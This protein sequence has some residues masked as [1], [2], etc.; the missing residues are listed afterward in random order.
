MLE[1]Q[2]I[3][4]AHADEYRQ[5]HKLPIVHHKALNAI[6]NCRTAK[7]GGHVDT[8][9]SCGETK[10]SYTPA[11]TVIALSVRH[12]PKNAGLMQERQTY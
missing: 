1:V 12:F 2:D 11:A 10:I 5:N 9:P 4:A 3:L 7:L 8:C 6:L